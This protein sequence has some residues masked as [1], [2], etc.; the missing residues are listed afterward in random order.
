MRVVRVFACEKIFKNVG[1]TLQ[2]SFKAV[3]PAPSKK[4]L[5]FG[6]ALFLQVD[7][8]GDQGLIEVDLVSP[9]NRLSSALFQRSMTIP[10][11]I[12]RP[13]PIG[14][15]VDLP[16]EAETG[17]YR[18]LVRID[19]N[20]IFNE[21]LFLLAPPDEPADSPD[22]ATPKSAQETPPPNASE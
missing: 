8:E 11:G 15:D 21:P 9:D 4:R 22:K 10:A 5:T 13:V 1:K 7:P 19:G 12:D 17:E 3:R 20:E 2:K 14:M 16:A 6:I 18:C